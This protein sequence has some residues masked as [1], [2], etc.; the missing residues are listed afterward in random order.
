MSRDREI[1]DRILNDMAEIGDW[2]SVADAL[3]AN[4]INS[5]HATENDVLQILTAVFKDNR[6][7]VGVIANNSVGSPL[8]RLP[9]TETPESVTRRIF[10]H[11]DD[12]DRIG[13]MMNIFIDKSDE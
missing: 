11:Q 5:F 2:D 4:G 9:S 7:Y 12:N 8:E 13:K 10:E 1:V 6:V 3:G